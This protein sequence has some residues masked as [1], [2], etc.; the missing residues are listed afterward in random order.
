MRFY[1][2]FR[3]LAAER[4]L[5]AG[6]DGRPVERSARIRTLLPL[7][8]TAMA[9]LL[10][11]FASLMILSEIGVNIAPLLAGAGIVGLAVGFGSQALVCRLSSGR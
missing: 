10:V 9:V 5:A 11:L 8:R 6:G 2:D 3:T 4:Y 7:A 1:R